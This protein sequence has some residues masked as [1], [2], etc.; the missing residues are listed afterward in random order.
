MTAIP[1]LGYW[2]IRALAQPIR[3]LLKYAGIEFNDKR[4]EFGEGTSIQETESLIKNWA[5]EKFTLGLDFPNLPYYIDRDVKLT[6]SLA[7][8]RYLA[9]KCD[10]FATDEKS[11]T[12]QDLVE[13]QIQDMR[14]SFIFGVLS[15]KAE[16]DK[17]KALFLK[18]TLPKQLELLS[19]FLGDNEWLVGKLNYVDFLAY[20]RLDWLRQFSPENMQKFENLT[21]YLKRFE[22]LPAISAYIN[23]SEFKSWPLLGPILSW[24]YSK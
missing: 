6:Q 12:R 13:Q 11:L 1:T 9:R 19:K 18:E 23:S 20:E 3:Y 8:M 4:Y 17:N 7:I 21:Q 22:S 14:W 2:D 5:P 15:N 10:L 24:G 16:Y